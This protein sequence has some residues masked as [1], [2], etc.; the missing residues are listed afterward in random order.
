MDVGKV[1]TDCAWPVPTGKWKRTRNRVELMAY[2]IEC[3]WCR[4]RIEYE[5]KFTGIEFLHGS[6]GFRFCEARCRD[7]MIEY[8]DDGF[9]ANNATAE[10]ERNGKLENSPI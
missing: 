1:Q 5:G 3:D 10:V 2:Y 6:A 9:L 7:R 4:K 8:L